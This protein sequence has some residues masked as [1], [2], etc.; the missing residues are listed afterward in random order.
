[1]TE[2]ELSKYYNLKREVQDL[3]ERIAEFGDGVK[4]SKIKEVAVS[5]SKSTKS[6]QETK[7][8]LVALLTEKRISA[9]EQYLDIERY[10]ESVED[11]EIRNIMRYRFLDLLKWEE[12]G[13]KLFQDRTWIAKKVRKYLNEE[14]KAHKAHD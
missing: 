13:E 14:K 8:E 11:V 10:I 1:M 3:E 12:I 2:K 4:S 7:V 6:I 5:G 9:L